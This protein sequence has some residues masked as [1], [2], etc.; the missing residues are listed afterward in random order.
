MGI[1]EELVRFINRIVSQL[2][3]HSRT[4]KGDKPMILVDLS[5]YRVLQKMSLGAGAG[6]EFAPETRMGW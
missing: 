3:T 1:F 6:I 5:P 4:K 2:R